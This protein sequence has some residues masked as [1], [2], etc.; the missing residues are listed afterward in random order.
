MNDYKDKGTSSDNGHSTI[1][2]QLFGSGVNFLLKLALG[3][4][5]GEKA[6][7]YSGKFRYRLTKWI[8]SKTI[9]WK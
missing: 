2:N 8:A 4:L 6:A 3:L 1:F 7:K 5:G 9:K